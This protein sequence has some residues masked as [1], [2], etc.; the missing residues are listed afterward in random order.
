MHVL[1]ICLFNNKYK[2]RHKLLK[3]MKIAEQ[4]LEFKQPAPML[5][6]LQNE[7]LFLVFSLNL[8]CFNLCPLSLFLPP[9]TSVNHI[10]NWKRPIKITES[11]SLLLPEL[12]KMN[13]YG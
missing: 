1:H 7:E 12:P 10:S 9:C 3:T 5:A 11:N 2:T 4:L 8:C 6:G 13:S